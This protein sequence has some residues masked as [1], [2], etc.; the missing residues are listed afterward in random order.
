MKLG[1]L[2]KSEIEKLES[3]INAETEEAIKA[4]RA[5]PKWGIE[6]YLSNNLIAEI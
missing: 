3:E 5:L 4:T 6:D 1:I 2:T